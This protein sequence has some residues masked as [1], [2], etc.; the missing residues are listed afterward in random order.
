MRLRST[1]RFSR[2]GMVAGLVGS[3]LVHVGFAGLLLALAV[4][5]PRAY[6]PQVY[7][8]ELVAAPAARETPR[9]QVTPPPPPAPPKVETK[10]SP[11]PPAPVPK[12]RTPPKVDPKTEPAKP[13]PA[14]P[15]VPGATPSTGTDVD[16][17]RVEQGIE[18]PFPEY[19]RHIMNEILRRWARPAGL[20]SLTAE[21]SFTILRD[22]SVKEIK[23]I[24]SS[25]SYTFDLEAQGAVEQA[26][27]DHAIRPLPDGWSADVLNVAFRF[28]PRRQ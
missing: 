5:Q 1:D 16:N 14:P 7:K 20:G 10:P 11:T 3:V 21:V 6:T 12:P 4:L 24:R 26:A 23:L 18:F 8:V 27:A 13:T 22:G 25:R 2:E 15:P 19:L 9:R 17:V 28:E